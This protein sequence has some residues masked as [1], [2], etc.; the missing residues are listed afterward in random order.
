MSHICPRC[1]NRPFRC[2]VPSDVRFWHFSDIQPALTNVRF[3]GQSGQW[4][5][6]PYRSRFMSTRPSSG[7]LADAKP[8]GRTAAPISGTASQNAGQ[9]PCLREAR[10][11]SPMAT[12]LWVRGLVSESYFRSRMIGVRFPGRA[13]AVACFPSPPD[14]IRACSPGEQFE[15]RPLRTCQCRHEGYGADHPRAL[16]VWDIE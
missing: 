6:A 2:T 4:P 14:P 9:L 7:F 13:I 15:I 10:L 11:H 5:T 16:F 3:W 12:R 8:S 1:G